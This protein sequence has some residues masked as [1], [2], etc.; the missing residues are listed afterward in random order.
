MLVKNKQLVKSEFLAFVYPNSAAFK[1]AGA[2][3]PGPK[4][5][6]TGRIQTGTNPVEP[7]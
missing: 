4:C 6:N 3:A 5:Y 1:A 2:L 7:R